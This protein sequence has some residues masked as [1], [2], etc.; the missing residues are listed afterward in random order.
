MSAIELSVSTAV[1]GYHICK[2]EWLPETTDTFCCQ[3]EVANK[4]DRFG[5]EKSLHHWS[6]IRPF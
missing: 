3:Q 2:D 5:Q 1:R 4:H 6:L